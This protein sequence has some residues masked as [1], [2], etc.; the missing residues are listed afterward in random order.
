MELKLI[1]S[2]FWQLLHLFYYFLI[3]LN[4]KIEVKNYYIYLFITF[5]YLLHYYIY[6][7]H[8]KYA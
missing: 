6:S 5:I 8:M 3:F 4:V 7:M 1:M 2:V